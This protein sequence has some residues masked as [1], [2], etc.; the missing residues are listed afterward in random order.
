[1]DSN[2]L[3]RI[4]TGP[5]RPVDQGF[6]KTARRDQSIDI[7]ACPTTVRHTSPCA[8]LHPLSRHGWGATV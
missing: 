7:Q 6:V 1:M 2:R 8:A 3:D 5:H 4:E